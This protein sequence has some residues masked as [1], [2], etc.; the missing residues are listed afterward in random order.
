MVNMRGIFMVVEGVDGVGKTT[1]LRWVQ[2][3]LVSQSVKLVHG[4]RHQ[5]VWDKFINV[6]PNSFLYYVHFILQTWLVIFPALRRGEVVLQD[7]YV[8]TVDSYL[9]DAGYLHNRMWRRLFAPLF[10]KSDLFIYLTASTAKICERLK[11]GEASDY[12]AGL[13]AN[14]QKIINRDQQY[15]LLLSKILS[16]V[17]IID[18]TNKSVEE[19]VKEIIQSYEK[20]KHARKNLRT[21]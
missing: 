1:T 14:P 9:P 6:Y 18:T 8:Q 11:K 10:L 3:L 20:E 12:H 19:S 16:S 13:I 15:K 2:E 7:R 21:Q 4:F 17:L 5:S